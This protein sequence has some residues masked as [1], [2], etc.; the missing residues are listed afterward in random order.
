MVSSYKQSIAIS[1]GVFG[2]S[3]VS[4]IF[5]KRIPVLGNIQRRIP[6]LLTKFCMLFLPF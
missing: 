6:R 1:L 5:F 4:V 2:V 3:I